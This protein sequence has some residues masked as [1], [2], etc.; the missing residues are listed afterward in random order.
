MAS[1]PT[2]IKNFINPSATNTMDT[3]G[4]EH[5]VQHTDANNEINA[6]ETEL[7]VNPSSIDETVT[8]TSSPSSVAEFLDMVAS[9]LKSIIGSHWYSTVTKSLVDLANHLINTSN[10]HNVTATQVGLG[11]VDNTSDATKN[12][13]VATLTNKTLVSPIIN[14]SFSGTAKATGSEVNTGTEDAKIVTPKAIGDSKLVDFLRGDGWISANETWT[15]ASADDP[16][17][18]FTIAGDKTSKYSPG[19]RIK[20]TQ[21]TVKYFI[22]TAVSYTSPNTTV[23][24]YGGTDYDLNNATISDNYYSFQKAPQGFPLNPVKWTV[25]VKNYTSHTQNS[26]AQSTWYN[27]GNVSITIPIG[28]WNV[29]YKIHAVSTRV[30]SG[31]CTEY[32]TLSTSPTSASDIDFIARSYSWGTI[33]D[34]CTHFVSK[35]LELSSKTTYYLNSMTEVNDASEISNYNPPSPLIIRAVCAYL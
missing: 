25:E 32:T 26:P 7:G 27:L 10:P 34:G 14:T 28:I 23:T 35:T 31:L 8:V 1:Y 19:M 2:S 33:H 6:I 30:S 5:D 9:Q 20:L 29:S 17:F 24:V 4:V 21:T 3:S 16:T 22:I 11:N 12:S 13:A 15:Y 18:T